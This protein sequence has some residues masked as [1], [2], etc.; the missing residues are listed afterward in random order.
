MKMRASIAGLVVAIATFVFAGPAAAG[1]SEVPTPD[2]SGPVPVTAAARRSRH[3]KLRSHPSRSI[4]SLDRCGL[5][6]HAR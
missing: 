3:A 1:P 4:R 6:S 2:V 5:S